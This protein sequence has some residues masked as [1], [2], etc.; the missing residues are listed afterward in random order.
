MVISGTING[1]PLP[2]LNQRS[3]QVDLPGLVHGGENTLELT[4]ATTLIN[5]L[6]IAH[7]LFDGKGGMPEPP[8]PGEA[9]GNEAPVMGNLPDTDYELPNAPMDMPTPREAVCHYGIF[10]ARV[11]P[12]WNR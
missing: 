10:G 9:V 6:R 2:A 7:P 12:Y 8:S 1:E 11:T 4:I 5:R 3:G